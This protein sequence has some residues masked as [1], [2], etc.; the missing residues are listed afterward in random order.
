LG[1]IDLEI[2]NIFL[3]SKWIVNFNIEGTWQTLLRNK[4][5]HSKA[6]TQVQAKSYDSFLEGLMRIKELALSCGSFRIRD[7]TQIRFW[8]DTWVGN[9]P[10]KHQ[11]LGIF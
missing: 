3:L 11:F 7:G 6:F 4:Y 8:E 1:I 9:N 10:V 5:L 2:P